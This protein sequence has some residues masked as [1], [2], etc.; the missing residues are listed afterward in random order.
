MPDTK[1]TGAFK[2]G[3]DLLCLFPRSTGGIAFWL[4]YWRDRGRTALYHR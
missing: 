2:Q 1:K 4:G 3:N